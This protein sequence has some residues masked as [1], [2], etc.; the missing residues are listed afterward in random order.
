[1]V[2][3]LPT[4]NTYD[5]YYRCDFFPIEHWKLEKKPSLGIGLLYIIPG[6]I[7]ILLYIPIL[8]VMMNKEFMKLSCYRIMIYLVCIDLMTLLFNSLLTGAF[9]IL[10]SVFC[11]HRLLMFITGQ[12]ALFGWFAGCITVVILALNRC[13]DVMLPTVADKLF[14]GIKVYFWLVGTTTYAACCSLLTSKASF[15]PKLYAWF[16]DPY[17]GNNVK[18][19]IEVVDYSNWVH[20]INNISEMICLGVLYTTLCLVMSIKYNLT[21]SVRISILQKNLFVQAGLI[22]LANFIASTIYV[23]MQFYAVGVEIVILGQVMWIFSHGSGSV[24]YLMFNKNIRERL[25]EKYFFNF[26]KNSMNRRVV[27]ISMVNKC[28]V[29]KD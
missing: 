24:I 9:S 26:S 3:F 28:T 8:F 11:E 16:F 2:L 25:L 15:T 1:M 17:F 13:L 23:Y 7:F 12:I 27:T 29:I 20:S 14:G 18:D 4:K 6:S 10:G 19:K 5:L 22:C 21:K